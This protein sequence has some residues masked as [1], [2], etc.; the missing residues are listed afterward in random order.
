VNCNITYEE[1]AAFA[2]G[3]LDAGREA[4]IRNHLEQ[5]D[6]CRKRLDALNEADGA[7]RALRPA[8]A[9]ASLILNVRRALAEAVDGRGSTEI[10]TLE[11]VAEYLRITPD[12][13]GEVVEELPAFELAGRIRVR[14][15][16]LV[17]WIEQ[18]ERDF[19]RQ[20][21]ASWAARSIAG[22]FGK[23]VA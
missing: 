23:G 2:S 22:R 6:A 13:L 20:A 10:M 12:Q 9:S 16:K 11:E 15:A 7:L 5:C 18:R 21:A 14:R 8:Q 4:E 1:L 19:T 3:D 17:E